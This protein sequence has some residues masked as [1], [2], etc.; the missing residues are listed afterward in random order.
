MGAP[1]TRT[2]DITT[3]LR[4]VYSYSSAEEAAGIID[5]LSEGDSLR[6][7][8]SKRAAKRADDFDVRVFDRKILN[9]VERMQAV[10]VE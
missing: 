6:L 1:N 5:T 7:E 4:S 10:Y 8:I 9:I 2:V 3:T